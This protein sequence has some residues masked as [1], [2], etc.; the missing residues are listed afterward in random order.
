MSSS[1]NVPLQE[2][3]KQ[4]SSK[5]NSTA[6]APVPAQPIKVF[7][8]LENLEN[9]KFG[10]QENQQQQQ[11]PTEETEQQGGGEE[12]GISSSSSSTAAAA[13]ASST[14]LAF[15]IDKTIV[16]DS[17]A[18]F[19]GIRLEKYGNHFVTVPEVMS[20]IRDKRSHQSLLTLPFDLEVLDPSAHALNAVSHFAKL[21]GDAALLSLTDLKV[22][23]LAYELETRINGKKNIREVPVAKIAVQAEYIKAPVEP[24]PRNERNDENQEEEEEEEENENFPIYDYDNPETSIQQPEQQQDEEEQEHDHPHH[25]EEE[26]EEIDPEI[27]KEFQQQT[28][29]K[30]SSRKKRSEKKADNR[31]PNLPGWGSWGGDDEATTTTTTTAETKANNEENEKEIDD[32]EG[33][34]ITPDN[35]AQYRAKQTGDFQDDDWSAPRF[36]NKKEVACITTDF[37]MQNV[38][39]QIGLQIVSVDGFR[40]REVKQWVL[41]CH[42]CS[43]IVHDTKRRFCPCCGNATLLRIECRVEKDGKV[44]Y[45]I[46]PKKKFNLRGTI[47]PLPAPKGGRDAKNP[48]LV[49]DQMFRN[50]YKNSNMTAIAAAAQSAKGN[51]L[52]DPDFQFGVTRTVTGNRPLWNGYG[53]RNPNEPKK[54]GKKKGTSSNN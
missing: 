42:S 43:A 46:N 13:A 39:L 38:L 15:S 36:K 28:K 12:G 11:Q 50:G 27:E 40:I 1:W 37:A 7:A 52:K 53:R 22:L 20:E 14:S 54:K 29:S 23:A 33:E 45:Y 44:H 48:I 30:R 4:N 35:I 49:E 9:S 8:K 25:K 21:T 26:E 51:P 10:I 34:W 5:S 24:Y 47:F 17:G 32:G 2:K 16:V 41:R 3:L 6:A 31:E 18:I 19:R